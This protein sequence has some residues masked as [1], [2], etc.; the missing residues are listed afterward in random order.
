MSA[1]EPLI[2]KP[3]VFSRLSSQTCFFLCLC[4]A[5]TLGLGGDSAEKE[6]GARCHSSRPPSPSLANSFSKD[7]C[8]V[9]GSTK[10][11]QSDLSL[12][13]SVSHPQTTVG[14]FGK[15]NQRQVKGNTWTGRKVLRRGR[16]IGNG[17]CF[18][19]RTVTIA[20]AAEIA[21]S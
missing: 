6:L 2:T 7:F 4:S 12:I 3:A 1:A 20:A 5:S 18:Q 21:S 15:A 8:E 13:T 17:I 11:T 19:R 14:E 9:P 16:R 10:H